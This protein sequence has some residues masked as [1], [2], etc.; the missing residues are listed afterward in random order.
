MKLEKS[1]TYT[2]S[3]SDLEVYVVNVMEQDNV[4]VKILANLYTKNFGRCMEYF[5]VFQLKKEDIKDWFEVTNPS[6]QQSQS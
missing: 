6:T 5:G 4:Y 2:N 3:T 1:K